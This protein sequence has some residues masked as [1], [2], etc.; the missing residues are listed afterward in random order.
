VTLADRTGG[1]RRRELVLA[2]ETATF[3]CSVAVA[4]GDGYLMA[5]IASDVGPAHAR[6]LLP[7]A[8]RALEM[9]GAAADDV[10]TVL[11]SLGPGSFTGLRIGVATARALAQAD[12]RLRLIGVPTLAAL[13]Q[14]LVDGDAC[15]IAPCFVPLI[16][17]RRGEVFAAR[18]VRC[19]DGHDRASERR[20]AAGR[21][22]ESA[23]KASGQGASRGATGAAVGGV[24]E[25]IRAAKPRLAVVRAD[26]LAAFLAPWPGALVGGDGA[27]LYADRLP[28][29]VYPARAVAA[30]SAAMLVRAWLARVPGIV[31]GIGHVLPVYGRRPDAARWAPKTS[32]VRPSAGGASEAEAE[33]RR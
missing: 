24:L 6:R 15:A 22:R 13:A 14:A 16:D 12:A 23:P 11:V 33:A 9:C 28:P 30:P 7:D 17:G 4:D 5:E 18:Y 19:G 26:D 27:R 32:G 21:G 3:A 1:S 20:G 8:Q 29:V 31:E 25:G 2:L 10:D